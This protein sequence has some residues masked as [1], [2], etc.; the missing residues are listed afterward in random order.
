M[1][2]PVGTHNYHER[3]W[4]AAGGINPGF[5]APEKEIIPVLSVA[6]QSFP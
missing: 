1:T 2:F 3:Y 4:L 6:M 5:Y